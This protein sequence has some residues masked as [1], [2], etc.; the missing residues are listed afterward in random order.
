MPTWAIWSFLLTLALV[1]LIAAGLSPL[2]AWRQPIYIA[3][4]FAGVIA[5]VLLL[6]QL[7]LAARKLPGIH[8]TSSLKC[9]RF[10][11]VSLVVLVLVHV[12]GLWITSPP[13]VIDA[14]LFRSPTPFAPW[15]VIAMWA[16]LISACSAALRRK[17]PMRILTWRVVHR[18]LSLVIIGG[19]VVHAMLIDGTM[20]FYS[21]A[22]LSA[23]LVIVAC[24][25]LL[26]T[27]V[28]PLP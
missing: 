9:H 6:F 1:P 4:G 25:V 22:V 20:E 21:K 11:G 15:G 7:L 16:L 26:S 2:L 14:L 18:T 12:L 10:I 3:A 23:A 17:L 24:L 8:A 13:D 27:F 28:K 19:T 5:M